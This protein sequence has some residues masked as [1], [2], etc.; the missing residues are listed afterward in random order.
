MARAR[1]SKTFLNSKGKKK[2][3][4]H[5]KDARRAEAPGRASQG[6]GSAGRSGGGKSSGGHGGSGARPHGGGG[7]AGGPRR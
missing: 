4:G 1:G 2:S 3:H 5:V 6:L 7:Q